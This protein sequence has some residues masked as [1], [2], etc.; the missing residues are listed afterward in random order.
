[1][2]NY[3]ND[4]IPEDSV[5]LVGVWLTGQ[6]CIDECWDAVTDIGGTREPLKYAGKLN[7]PGFGSGLFVE[8]EK[9]VDF[10]IG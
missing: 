6:G 4:D 9:N 8:Y 3:I 10:L 2:T 7:T 5:V 1:M